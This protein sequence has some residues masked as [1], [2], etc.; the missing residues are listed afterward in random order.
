MVV[1]DGFAEMAANVLTIV[2]E[3]GELATEIDLERAR[4]AGTTLGAGVDGVVDA[5]AD[6]TDVDVL[7]GV[8]GHAGAV[9]D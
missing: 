1:T 5:H 9:L 2:A 6:R 3:A 4:G 7:S 8:Q